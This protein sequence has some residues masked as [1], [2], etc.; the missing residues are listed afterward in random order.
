M[1][2]LT[3]HRGY[4]IEHY[5]NKTNVFTLNKVLKTF[6]NISRDKGEI[7]AKEWINN[8]IKFCSPK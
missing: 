2:S 4:Q 3:K 6:K 5:N 1:R 7:K 8:R